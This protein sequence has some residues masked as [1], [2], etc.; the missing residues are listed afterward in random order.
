MKRVLTARFMHET[1]TFSRVKTDMALIRRRDFH[2]EN[3]IPRAFRGTRSALGASFEAADKYGWNL[4]HPVSANPNPSGTMTDEAFEAIAGTIFEAAKSRAPIDGV[5]LHLHGAMVTASHEDAE[6]EFLARLRARLG[7]QVPIIATLDLHANVTR[8]MAENANALIAFR[9]YPHVDMYERA[10]QAAALLERTMRGEIRPLTVIARRPML[11]G[12]DRGRHESPP[13]AAL[14]RRAAV[15]EESGAALAVSICAGF[16]YADIHDAGPSVT[17]TT[18]GADPR[19]QAI[20]ESFMD[21]AWETREFNSVE[22][23][24]VGEAVA[25]AKTGRPGD[26]P[27]VVADYTD[28]PG[29]G[30][31]GDATA[32]LGGLLAAGVERVAFHAIYDPQAVQQGIAAGVGTRTTLVLGGK[33]DPARGGGPLMLDGEVVCLTNGRFVAYGP[34]GGG[35]ERNYGPSMVF[36]VGGIDIVVITNNGQATDL[37]QFTSLGVD[38]AR[39]ATVVVKSMQHFRAAFAPIARAV[40]LVDSGALCTETYDRAQF[41]RLRRPIWPL[42]PIADPRPRQPS[43]SDPPQ[44]L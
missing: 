27:L 29:V 19:G 14:L 22:L 3:E 9:T 32:F 15:I 7:Q 39:Y 12:L 28:N 4:V 42:E 37:A 23:L 34:M 13:M 2:L 8:R 30:G 44:S 5:L 25:L 18:D 41:T 38:P 36:R 6:G 16:P 43:P 17:V 1:N 21:A 24:T 35:V 20:A 33:T 31:Y 11:Y 40:A 10:W 26:R